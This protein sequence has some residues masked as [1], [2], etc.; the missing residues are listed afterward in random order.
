MET[1]QVFQTQEIERELKGQ[2]MEKK[3]G[4]S[5]LGSQ[6]FW[7]HQQQVSFR[8]FLRV[9]LEVRQTS[10]NFNID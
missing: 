2:L 7:K 10:V 4:C 1:A 5:S 3:T 6:R 9:I 8:N